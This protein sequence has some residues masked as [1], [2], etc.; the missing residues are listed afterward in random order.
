MQPLSQNI[1][2]GDSVTFAV[3]AT[4]EPPLS[5]QWRR[6]G[7]P[8]PGATNAQLVLASVQQSDAGDYSALVSNSGGSTASSAATLTVRLPPILITRQPDSAILSAGLSW[9]LSVEA[10]SPLGIYPLRFEW[11][12]DGV[13]IRPAQ[14]WGSYLNLGS[15]AV[16]NSGT[17][18]VRI[19]NSQGTLTS[20]PAVLTVLPPDRL[21]QWQTRAGGNF[22]AIALGNGRLVAVG[23]AGLIADSSDGANWSYRNSGTGQ[24]LRDVAFGAGQFVVVG[25]NGVVLTSPDAAQWTRRDSGVTNALMG[26]VFEQGLFV[27][28][29]SGGV[30]L[31]SPDGI[32]WTTR[33]AN[34]GESYYDITF[35]NGQFLA[36]GSTTT[37]ANLAP[38]IVTSP[39]GIAWTNQVLTVPALFTGVAFGNGLFAA[40]A[41][42]SWYWQS[43]PP[44]YYPG[45]RVFTSTDGRAWEQ[46]STQDS[47]PSGRGLA[48][49]GVHFFAGGSIIQTS[50]DGVAW[51]FRL[52]SGGENGGVFFNNSFVTVGS[53]GIYQSE[54]LSDTAPSILRQPRNI[55]VAEGDF[56]GLDAGVQGT[57][58]LFY[59]WQKDGAALTNG[60]NAGYFIFPAVP[61]DA[62]SYTLT[63]SNAFGLVTSASASLV[64]TQRAPALALSWQQRLP[65]TPQIQNVV[66]GNGIFVGLGNGALFCSPDGIYW[67]ATPTAVASNIYSTTLLFAEG[68]FVVLGQRWEPTLNYT[69]RVRLNSANGLDWTTE[70]GDQFVDASFF[71]IVQGGGVFAG[72]SSGYDSTNQTSWQ[73]LYSSPD[74]L[75]W[76]RRYFQYTT[77]SSFNELAFGNGR[78]VAMGSSYTP[79]TGSRVEV[80]TS[81]DGI[82]WTRSEPNWAPQNPGCCFGQTVFGNGVFVTMGAGF[83]ASANGSDWE[84]RPFPGNGSVGV[85]LLRYSGG[86]FIAVGMDYSGP[87][88]V[89]IALMSW[90]GL[91]WTM[92]ESDFRETP[93]ASPTGMACS[94]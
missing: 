70:A 3:T 33:R 36:V 5:Y 41:P 50:D 82:A 37:P 42:P 15:V 88:P 77:N 9:S 52:A 46:R 80:L 61:G 44:P 26:L 76:T 65:D 69:V 32:A 79:Q 75:A 14:D 13:S 1:L 45:T 64:V 2:L 66:F 31:T 78:F 10:Q 81:P 8:I 4:G 16:S 83:A 22:N 39:D 43:Y 21:D 19:S 62:G 87:S 91:N 49:G 93:W 24:D 47:Y 29:G 72:F 74:G 54:P 35:G 11:L 17:Y 59:H 89:P 73:A 20:R 92:R 90:D 40:V 86:R 30:V 6:Y 71:S 48:Y 53:G 67:Q 55:T 84:Q 34:D 7:S 28:V 58:P 38:V 18:T 60:T 27:A 68:Q 12:K 51:R 63:V 94:F 25:T 85:N 56:A 23:S 57:S